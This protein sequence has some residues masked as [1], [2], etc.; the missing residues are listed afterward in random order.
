MTGAR[1]LAAAAFFMSESDLSPA[2]SLGSRRL[3][4]KGTVLR[5]ARFCAWLGVIIG[6]GVLGGW[7]LNLEPLQSFWPGNFRMPP[8]SGICTLLCSMVLLVCYFSR[9]RHWQRYFCW[10][11]AAIVALIS[12]LTLVEYIGAL[13]LGIDNPFFSS[14]APT[15]QV[16]FPDRMAPNAAL[17][18]LVYSAAL[19]LLGQGRRGI[20][21]AQTLALTGLLIAF[22]AGVGYL[23]DA[24]AFVSLASANRIALHS[25]LCLALLGLSILF[26]RPRFGAA[27]GFLADNPGG[28]IARRFLVLAVIAPVFLG[29]LAFRG[30]QMG[31]YDHGFACLLIVLSGVLVT[32]LLTLRSVVQLNHI[33]SQ[34]NR[35]GVERLHADVREQGALEASRMKSEFVANVSHELRTPM[36]GVLG[37]TNLL[38]RLAP[39][40]RA[41]RAG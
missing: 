9:P 33:E 21:M 1:A 34:R 6:F 5:G 30:S 40:R 39:L 12:A 29:L 28:I 31:Y 32:S 16:M 26:A 35:L 25:V 2:V 18:F 19:V 4:E 37:M 41:A 23:F 14:T 11:L 20:V 7:A 38:L 24:Q 36:N 3:L 8:N 22:L 15:S 13:S 27:A 10:A 17:G